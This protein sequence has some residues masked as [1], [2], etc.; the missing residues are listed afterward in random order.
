MSYLIYLHGFNSSPQSEKAKLTVEF[1]E[2]NTL[3]GGKRIAVY[4]PP[5]SA[6]PLDAIVQIHD[7]IDSLGRE[8]LIG[9][10][11]SSLG[12]F[13]SI[14]LQRYYSDSSYT[15]K[16]VLL[17]PAVRPYE[18]LSD[19]LGENQNMYTGERYIVEESHMEDLKSLIS[20][21]IK[22]PEFTMLLTQTGDEVLN[23]QEA[24]D[25]LDGAAMWIQYGGSHA[26]DGFSNVLPVIW[27]F[28]SKH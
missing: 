4:V 16:V 17:N 20:Q 14:Y 5:L 1:F 6:S 21:S 7:L 10:I 11:G 26:F 24:I 18:L 25:Y 9:F 13:Y 12:G 3:K 19:Y 8:S 2:K 22:N 15:P 23:F 27:E 28:F